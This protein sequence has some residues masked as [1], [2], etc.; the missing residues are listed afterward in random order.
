MEVVE[1]VKLPKANI[2]SY[3][4]QSHG[5]IMTLVY[6]TTDYNSQDPD[7]INMAHSKTKYL[8]ITLPSNVELFTYAN[9]GEAAWINVCSASK[10]VCNDF[11]LSRTVLPGDVPVYKYKKQFPQ[12][13]LSGGPLDNK[14]LTLYSGIIHC[15][16]ESR[17]TDSI[18][19]TEII[20]NIDGQLYYGCVDNSTHQLRGT[21][22]STK[23]YSQP[24]KYYSQHYKDILDSDN[25]NTRPE[26]LDE[27]PKC[28][29]LFLSEA[30]AI[31]CEHCNA[32]YL[33]DNKII[34]V[35]LQACL[36]KREKSSLRTDEKEVDDLVY[37][38][39]FKVREIDPHIKDTTQFKTYTFVFYKTK[40]FI[41]VPKEA[42]ITHEFNQAIL[43]DTN[44]QA[45]LAD[46]KDSL[47][48]YKLYTSLNSALFKC[49][50]PT[51]LRITY[52]P[53]EITI[54]FKDV[55]IMTMTEEEITD[56]MYH[57]LQEVDNNDTNS[58]WMDALDMIKSNLST[59]KKDGL[60]AGGKKKFKRTKRT[61]RTSRTKISIRHN[62]RNKLLKV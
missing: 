20:H 36:V 58:L 22:N 47:I 59:T 16:P 10:Y 39:D 25:Y 42:K 26:P 12:V 43:A 6:D 44:L 53:K 54:T 23:Y 7:Y 17:T 4:I 24:T 41:Q 40:F 29:P 9:L 50:G 46:T 34:Q 38:K 13:R 15:I 28:G 62:S 45:T 61:K 56:L 1:L 33:D 35:H 55:N 52:Y 14:S 49:L 31:I 3:V 32:T 5:A 57:H 8:S 11:E 48:K 2:Y 37:F 60:T 18:Q 30:I 19:K 27:I 51:L 21:Y